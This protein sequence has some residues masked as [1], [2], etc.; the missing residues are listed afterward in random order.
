MADK[1]PA[2]T[3]EL[4]VLGMAAVQEIKTT[5][6]GKKSVEISIAKKDF[7]EFLD[8]KGITKE[9]RGKIDEVQQEVLAEGIRVI[10]GA[11]CK[12]KAEEGGSIYFGTG[13]GSITVNFDG[14]ASVRTP[15]TGVT[16][17]VFGHV[18]VRQKLKLSS[19]L[20][21]KGGVLD[22]VEALAMKA[23]GKK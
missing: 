7:N 13:N 4:K 20:K 12:T 15:G 16:N 2:T 23:F 8:G 1:T 5:K 14:K 10:G 21:A 3:T 19:E 6:D 17:E 9:V 11:V 18:T 22:E